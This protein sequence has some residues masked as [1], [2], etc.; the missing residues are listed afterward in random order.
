M[1][2]ITVCYI[3]EARLGR[4]PCVDNGSESLLIIYQ[5]TPRL[6]FLA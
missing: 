4:E 5:V 1:N 3:C 6:V 2:V